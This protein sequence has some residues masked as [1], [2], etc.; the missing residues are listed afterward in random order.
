V[1]VGIGLNSGFTDEEVRKIRDEYSKG[2]SLAELSRRY[3]SNHSTL[4]D[5]VNGKTYKR[6]L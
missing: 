4:G 3:K 6:L 2:T 1:R 5:M